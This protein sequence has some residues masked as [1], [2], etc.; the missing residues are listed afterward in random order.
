MIYIFKL[1]QRCDPKLERIWNRKL[2]LGYFAIRK[3][4][5]LKK[6]KSGNW[7]ESEIQF[8]EIDFRKGLFLGKPYFKN[9]LFIKVI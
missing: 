6:F 9:M 5:A 1:K 7:K 4:D 8:L 3:M 2:W